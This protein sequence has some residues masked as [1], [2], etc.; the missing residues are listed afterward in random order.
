MLMLPT[1]S[2]PFFL[3]HLCMVF[4]RNQKILQAFAQDSRGKLKENRIV[5]VECRTPTT[6]YLSCDSIPSFNK[7]SCTLLK[8]SPGSFVCSRKAF[9]IINIIRFRG[10]TRKCLLREPI[11]EFKTLLRTSLFPRTCRNQSHQIISDL[12]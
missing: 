8:T 10:C 5:M 7:S 9:I 4:H 6:P 12:S 3:S 2:L 11:A 1:H